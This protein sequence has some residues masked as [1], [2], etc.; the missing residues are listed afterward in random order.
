MTLDRRSV[1]K[2]AGAI[3][4]A[5]A[6]VSVAEGLVTSTYPDVGG[7][8]TYC[9]GETKGAEWGKTYTKEQCDEK[10]SARLVEFN[11]GVNSCVFVELPDTRRAALVSLS[12]NIGIAAFCKSTVVRK[13]NA[14]DV[15]G[16]CD[17]MLMWNK[18]KG[19]VWRGLTNRRQKERALCLEGGYS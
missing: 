4:L 5:F 10:L 9:Y 8:P 13:L 3:A 7:V 14:G 6:I 1:A 18:V 11:D 19:V 15:Q 17:A 16:G 12:Y 2:G